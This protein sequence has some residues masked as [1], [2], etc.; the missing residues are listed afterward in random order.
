MNR[1][2]LLAAAM[3][4]ALPIISACGEDPPIAPPTGSIDGL[5]SIEGQGLDGVSVTLSNGATA[6]TANGGM[7]RFDGVEAGAYTVTISNYPDDATFNNTSSPATIASDGETVTINFPGTWIRTAAIMGTVTVENDGLPG[8][9][10]KLTGMSD[11]ETLTD[12]NGQYAFTGLRKGNY[13]VEISGFDD[14]DVAFGSTASTAELAVGESK[15]IPFEGTY[16]RTAAI[17]GQVS[18]ENVGLENVTV[19]LQ[20]RDEERT[21]TTNAAGQYT[22]SELRSGDYS[23]GITNPDTDKYGFDV[24]S[25]NVT[26][27]HGETGSVSFKGILLRTASI[28]GTVTVEGVGGIEGVLVSV[29]GEGAELEKRTNAAGQFSFTE[30][31]AGDYSIG[32]TGFDDDLYG[33]EKTT[34]TTTVALQETATVPFSG[35]ELRTAGFE[36]TVTVEDHPI[37][38]VTVTVTGGPKDE[39]HTRV[40]N[41]AGYYMVDRLHAGTYTITIS[42][43]DANEYEFVATAK[44]TDVGLRETATVAFQGDLL[45][46]AGIS[47]RVSVE[48][49]GLDGIT[50]TLS[51]DADA[52]ET[53]GDGGQYA[54]TGLAEGDYNVAIAGWDEAAYNFDV[55]DVDVPVA[56]DSSVIQN[57]DGMHTRTASISGMLYLDEV[58]A[59]DMHDEG[60]PPFAQAG[61]PLLL[62]GPGVNDV[63]IGM[64]GDDG[65][66]AFEGLMAG[67]YRVLID[68]NE[69]VATGLTTAGFR[70]AGELTGQ[71]VGVAAAAEETVNFPFRIVMQTIVAGAVLGYADAED[72]GLP[73]AGV[74]LELYPNADDADNGTNMLGKATTDSVGAATFDFA[75]AMDTGAGGQGTDHL[76]FIKVT[77]T[78]DNIVVSDNSDIEVAYASTARVSQAPTVVR[79]LNTMANFQWW[80]KSNADA[81]DGNEFLEGWTATNGMETDEDGLAT[82]SG[83]VDVADLPMEFMVMLDT[84]GQPDGSEKWE[85]SAGLMYEHTGLEHPAMNMSDSP[86]HDL[87]AIY[88]TWKTQSL[89]L[90]VYREADDEPGFSD[91]RS[92]LP[93]GDH[94]PK[95]GVGRDM[96]VELMKRDDRGR[97]RTLEYDHDFDDETDPIEA[98]GHF[99]AGGLKTFTHLPADTEITVR[100]RVGTNRVLVSEHA[101]IE[102]FGRDLDLGATVGSF[103]EASGGGPEVRLCT[104]SSD[105]TDDWC[106]TYAYQWMTGLVTGNVG[107]ERGHSVVLTATS[108]HGVAGDSV[109]TAGDNANTA[110]NE[111][112]TYSVHG[113]QD[114]EYSVLAISGSEDY[115]IATTPANPNPGMV[116]VYHDEYADEE[117]E[118]GLDTTWVGTRGTDEA[119]WSTTRQG[120]SVRGYVGNDNGDNLLRGDEAT[121]GV[122]LTLL[123]GGRL[124]NG[125]L[126]GA[127]TVATTTTDSRG[128]YAFD[129]LADAGNTYRV[130]ASNG[131]GYRALRVLPAPRTAHNLSGTTRAMVYPELPSDTD[132]DKPQWNTAT[133]RTT[134]S[135]SSYTDDQGTTDTD[136]DVRG[137]W[138]NF[139]LVW[140]NGTVAGVVSNASGSNAGIDVRIYTPED[141][142]GVEVGTG[143]SGG[144]ELANA[145]E[146]AYSA[147]VDDVGWAVPLLGTNGRPDD[148]VTPSDVDGDG[149]DDNQAP[150]TLSGTV[151]GRLDHESLGTLHVYSRTASANDSLGAGV[152]VSYR[153][154][155]SDAATYNDTAS[156]DATAGWPR[157]P[158]TETTDNTSNIGTI[159][160]ASA[161]VRFTFG[162][163]NAAIPTGSSV[164]LSAAN[165][166]CAGFSCEVGYN[167]TGSAAASQITEDTITVKVTAANGYDDHAYSL[168]VTRQNPIGNTLAAANIARSD[169]TDLTTHTATAAGTDGFEFT[170]TGASSV[171]LVFILT[172]YGDYANRNEYCA[173][174]VS[175]RA[176][177][178]NAI[179]AQDDDRDDVCPDTRYRLSGSSGSG[180]PYDVIVTS[181]DGEEKVYSLRVIDPT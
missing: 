92:P 172:T 53:T 110:A 16:L 45:R 49:V 102:T 31:H 129:E 175:V 165:G 166:E 74:E 161:S 47:G 105:S 113:L 149:V 144:F 86:G 48:G 23:I 87:G 90:G 71:V 72:H 67:S 164:E 50:V 121:E 162:T 132:L 22:F 138:Q 77:G 78:P 70:F 122:T 155:G 6:T 29:Q 176:T 2:K 147:R 96:T 99:G 167:A 9:T 133:G 30:L 142:D 8:V 65:S 32:I 107:E 114:G 24:T 151:S 91:Y 127:T 76:V 173:Q 79:V 82:Y 157:S 158:D 101:D 38:G 61:I 10:V 89:V 35:I 156:A 94:R 13:T 83:T 134:N 150:T 60:E 178:G 69:E 145:L 130:R 59:N 39:E 28:M 168:L 42:D 174:R 56:Q 180:T 140:E 15:V 55:S 85:Q 124:R 98:K 21:A 100:F 1:F 84:V 88:V 51:G 37:P 12:A 34:A 115:S 73:M 75:R 141:D 58:D 66:Y 33:F 95:A 159:S 40:T 81:R 14:E 57:F 44:T 63:R 179:S 17:T 52:T 154:Q 117:D 11:A 18:V 93:R 64:T 160:W 3:L 123:R 19:S 20:G 119:S 109:T 111:G 143:A 54:F 125:V 116:A 41:D 4:L 36:G 104:A 103:G 139:A 43:F 108:E 153:I 181:E 68:M 46:T 137:T 146:G 7:F 120:L 177:G 118:M 163:R 97:L 170:T 27:A 128:Y 112:G 148:D 106:A 126:S 136:D 152:R 25:E 5:V 62:Q 131:D 80:V 26:I 135:T 171:N 169:T